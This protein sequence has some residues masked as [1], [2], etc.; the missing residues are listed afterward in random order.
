[1]DRKTALF[2]GMGVELVAVVLIFIYL[3]RWLDDTYGLK[4][5][6][7]ALSAMVALVVW[8]VHLLT[9]VRVLAKQEKGEHTKSK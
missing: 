3:G 6:A 7:T 8:V 9:V 2:I 5:L 1:M 4:G